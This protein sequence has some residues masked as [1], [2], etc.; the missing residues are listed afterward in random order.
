VKNVPSEEIEAED[1]EYMPPTADGIHLPCLSNLDIPYEPDGFEPI[2]WDLFGAMKHD[3]AAY[4]VKTDESGKSDMDYFVKKKMD[5]GKDEEL[6]VCPPP[7]RGAKIATSEKT[8]N[9]ATKKIA[10]ARSKPAAV[11]DGIQHIPSKSHIQLPIKPL[12]KSTR[13]T[14]LPSQ[15]KKER[16]VREYMVDEVAQLEAE[17]RALCDDTDFGIDLEL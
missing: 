3:V 4:F 16:F 17:E 11:K 15:S 8:R 2:D 14:M 10:P 9:G 5:F 13:T 7:L 6:P 1:V 12:V